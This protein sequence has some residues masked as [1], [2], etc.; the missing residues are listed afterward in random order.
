M[1]CRILSCAFAIVADSFAGAVTSAVTRRGEHVAMPSSVPLPAEVRRF[2]ESTKW[3][4]A[5]TYAS[6]WPHEYIVRTP[7]NAAMLLALA[8]HIF[9]HGV[10]GHFYSQ[11]RK[12]H[13][14]AGKVYW[15]MDDSLDATD[16]VNR[17][18]EDQTYEARL[19]AGTLPG[20]STTRTAKTG[21][22][23]IV[24]LGVNGDL[25]HEGKLDLPE[26]LDP[27]TAEEWAWARDFI[28]RRRWQEAV[29]YRHT[30]PHEYTVREWERGEVP[31]AEFDRF[32]ALVRRCGYADFYYRIRHLYWAVDG[33]KYWT[34]GW[35]VTET[36]VINR[37]RVDAPEPWKTVNEV[38][39]RP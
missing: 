19:A 12:Y 7:E 33:F 25:L 11:V 16:L 36:T 32:V 20:N 8:R 10:E 39:A 30:A 4:F 13:H 38:S 14:E 34:M 27:P 15:S 24:G 1:R 29:T 3:T 37:A 18:D 28:G 17:C 26:V 9:E 21:A 5:K 6:T 23:R 31:D 35:P 2:V 22:A